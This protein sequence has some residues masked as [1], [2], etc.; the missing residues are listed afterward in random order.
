MIMIIMIKIM[1]MMIMM[2]IMMMILMMIDDIYRE[3]SIC[4]GFGRLK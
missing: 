2:M 3:F 4:L 1:I